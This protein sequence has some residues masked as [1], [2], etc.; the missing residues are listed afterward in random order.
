MKKILIIIITF[1]CGY[2]IYVIF[3]SCPIRSLTG[4]PCPS[5]GITRAC[6]SV[7]QGDLNSALYYH[8]LFFLPFLVAIISFLIFKKERSQKVKTIYYIFLSLCVI[9]YTI[10]YIIRLINNQIP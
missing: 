2:G 4:I 8:P 3:A 7:I 9:L 6:F 5:C 10:V 1:L